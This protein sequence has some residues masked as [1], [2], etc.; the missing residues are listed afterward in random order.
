MPNEGGIGPTREL[1]DNNNTRSDFNALIAL[2]IVPEKEQREREMLVNIVMPLIKE[3][4]EP[5]NGLKVILRVLNFVNALIV[6]GIGPINL[7]I[8]SA[9]TS[10]DCKLPNEVGIGPLS[11]LDSK[12]ND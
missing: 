3:G 12:F 9:R 10:S 5:E 8:D 2:G 6:S 11:E 1:S 7:F 4:I